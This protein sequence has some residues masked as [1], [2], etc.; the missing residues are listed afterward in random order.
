V[1]RTQLIDLLATI[2]ATR[3]PFFSIVMFVALGA[4]L[5]L[6]L[7]WT[8]KVVETSAE[9]DY[10]E[11]A[12]CD[13]DISYS[14]G[15]TQDDLTSISQME[16]VSDVEGARV[17]FATFSM[18]DQGHVAR[19]MSDTSRTNLARCVEGTMPTQADQVAVDSLFAEKQGVSVGDTI[20]LDPDGATDDDGM[21]YLTCRT[22][23]V[24]AL[25]TRPDYLMRYSTTRGM[26][27]LYEGTAD[28]YLVTAGTAFDDTAYDGCFTDAYVRCSSLD[29]LPTLGD[30]YASTS[31]TISDR[32][33]EKGTALSQARYDSIREQSQAKL[34]DAQQQID[35]AQGQVDDGEQQLVDGQAAIDDAEQRLVDGQATIDE[36]EQ[37]LVDG[38][39][40]IDE[41]EAQLADAQEQI[42]SSQAQV[43]DGQAQVDAAEGQLAEAKSQ[44]DEGQSAYDAA[45]GTLEDGLKAAAT[46]I[47]DNGFG[48]TESV[49]QIADSLR[50]M[51]DEVTDLGVDLAQAA[52]DVGIPEG[53]LL[54]YV[55]Q[56]Q[57]EIDD[58]RTYREAGTTLASSRDAYDAGRAALDQ[59]ESEL[60]QGVQRLADARQQL[61]DGKAKVQA[62]KD[63]LAQ[64]KVELQQA[65][66]ALA[67]GKVTLQESKDALEQGKVTLQ[68]SKDKLASARERLADSQ[69][70]Y[71]SMSKGDWIVMGR[72]SITG[73]VGVRE[74]ITSLSS[75]RVSMAFVFFLVGLLVCYT[76][77]SRI[78]REQVV[79]I[80]TKKALGFRGRE[81]TQGFLLYT[82]I[83]VLAG[84]VLAV[85]MAVLVVEGIFSSVITNNF[86]FSSVS[87]YLSPVDTLAVG[88]LE[89]LLMGLTTWLACHR[90]LRKQAVDLLKGEEPP[91]ARTRFFEGW[92]VWKRM[93]LYSQSIVSNFLNDK[94]RVS[95]TLIGVAGCTVLVTMAMTL[96]GN[97]NDSFARQYDAI[98]DYDS[99]VK[100]SSSD[101][102]A[103]ERVEGAIDDTGASGVSVLHSYL[104]V[105]AP[106]GKTKV[107]TLDVPADSEG[108][109][110]MFHLIDASDGQERQL[111]SNGVWV[112]SA[113]AAR[114]G[115]KAGDTIV[116]RD[117][118][119]TKRE[120]SI[121]GVFEYYLVHNEVV[122]SKDY[123]EQAFGT[124]FEPNSVFV[125][126]GGTDQ[127]ALIS[128]LENIDGFFSY[129]D[130]HASNMATFKQYQSLSMTMVV[131][132]F[133]LSVVM[134]LVVL[135]NLTTMFI[136]EKRRDLIVLMINGFSVRD[137]KRYIYR[138]N[139]ALTIVGTAIGIVVGMLMG[140]LTLLSAETDTN[141]FIHT[142]NLMAI[143]VAALTTFILAVVVNLIALR[144]I[145]RMRLTD[146]NKM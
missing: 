52:R 2:R 79:S 66:D 117:L 136:E 20:S 133:G 58:Y 42:E 59:K 104:S 96:Y 144:R 67:Q 23:T 138:D 30:S 83:A 103:R 98:Y 97:V 45:T 26:T 46:E 41:S 17:A 1:K 39:A 61:A 4:T 27:N 142:P 34:D 76:A 93:P 22:F 89:V 107:T 95:S 50:E 80:G 28:C 38:Q 92:T 105:L 134:A 130:E 10:A 111:R 44:L 51:L 15:I 6:G 127:D 108:F 132:F 62:A 16:G 68:E 90:L 14:Y 128:K 9:K 110:G 5:F 57:A 64:G 31:D 106:S 43:D 7:T 25:V 19:I 29:S 112:S 120:L 100:L 125:S 36:S 102:G 115:V 88:L 24:T 122:M 73:V 109:S 18:N 40:T 131:V 118:S 139:I 33:A 84:M 65:K 87:R 114:E 99:Y 121:A 85:L 77:V 91:K 11:Q 63:A 72:R 13:Y 12:L 141:L 8:S 126:L 32:L 71:D 54:E 135:L 21:T 49:D 56:A 35:D 123:Y 48:G 143:G 55:D 82:T 69:A 129:V 101:A 75:L 78:V 146:I 113:Y 37:R 86:D 119:G 145:P 74:F 124:T 60:A 137:A 70:S 81:I 47:H 94:L 116:V 140:Y 3:V 53:D